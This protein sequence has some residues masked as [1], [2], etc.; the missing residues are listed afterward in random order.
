MSQLQAFG[1][2]VF[3]TL[4]MLNG[5]IDATNN[6]KH[7]TFHIIVIK[8]LINIM[9]KTCFKILMID[10]SN[11]HLKNKS[12]FFNRSVQMAHEIQ[13]VRRLKDGGLNKIAAIQQAWFWNMCSLTKICM[14]W[15]KFTWGCSYGS[16]WWSINGR[17]K[18][19][20]WTNDDPVVVLG[21][22]LLGLNGLKFNTDLPK[23]NTVTAWE[24]S[25][26][27]ET[28]WAVGVSGFAIN[29]SNTSGSG[30]NEFAQN[31]TVHVRLQCHN[32]SKKFITLRTLGNVLRLPENKSGS[33]WV[34][35]HLEVKNINKGHFK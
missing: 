28:W 6:Y 12:L 4:L 23:Q 30:V 11:M 18:A 5:R 34:W 19:F 14:F 20:T 3:Q 22:S 21:P 13:M 24:G 27:D 26:T 25:A 33:T 17:R 29:K 15:L 31:K 1:Y 9:L 16:H 7:M 32:V 35:G 8:H 10:R 2:R